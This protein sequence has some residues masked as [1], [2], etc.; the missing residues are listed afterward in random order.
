MPEGSPLCHAVIFDMDGLLFDSETLYLQAILA[1]AR[2]LGIRFTRADFPELVGRSWALNRVTLQRHVGAD[3]DV[4]VFRQ[5]WVRHYDG[6]RGDLALKPGVRELLDRLDALRLKRAI[7]TSSSHADVA[8][9]LALHGL[10]GRFDAV[11]AAGDYASGKPAPDPYL[12]AAEVLGLEPAACLALED[13]H[14]G[15]RA[16]AA[17]GMRTVMVPDLLPPTEELRA[18]CHRVAADLHEVRALLD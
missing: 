8:H 14:N 12:R 2:E 1:A 9:N 4:E 16:A 7:C 5:A 10:E 6:M 3:G 13:S 17:A 11:V 15:V 18:L